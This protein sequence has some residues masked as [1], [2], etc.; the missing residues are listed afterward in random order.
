MTLCACTP[1]LDQA[2]QLWDYLLAFGVG[3]NILCVIA[4]VYMMRDDLLAHPSCVPR[5]SPRYAVGPRLNEG[6]ETPTLRRRGKGR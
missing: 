3:L 6:G 5:P 4:Q 1:P 2:V